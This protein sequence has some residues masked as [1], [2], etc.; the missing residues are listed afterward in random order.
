MPEHLEGS[1]P[2]PAELKVKHEFTSM[3]VA[4]ETILTLISTEN[5]GA[6]ENFAIE[7]IKNWREEGNMRGGEEQKRKEEIITEFKEWLATKDILI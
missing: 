7:A 3:V 5:L 4:R 6:A 1:K 2:S